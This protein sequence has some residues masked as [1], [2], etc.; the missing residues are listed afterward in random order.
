MIYGIFYDSPVGKIRL[1][2]DEEF[3][4]RLDFV[5][6]VRNTAEKISAPIAKAIEWLDDYF[7][8]VE[9]ST[10]VPLKLSGTPFQLRVWQELKKI[11]Y[12]Q[13]T[14]YGQIA[15]TIAEERNVPRISARAVGSAVGKNPISL[16][17]PCHRVIGSDGK[18]TGYAG[19]LGLKK[20]FLELEG[21]HVVYNGILKEFL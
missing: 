17:I 7:V 11:P 12:G 20:K 5:T 4:L 10:D 3:L 1:C 18:L 19:G 16:I 14:T 8:G 21:F 13:T 15:A 9:P 2:S 6:T